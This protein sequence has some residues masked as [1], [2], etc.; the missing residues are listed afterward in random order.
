MAGDI[1]A[2]LKMAAERRRKAME[3]EGNATPQPAQPPQAHSPSPSPSGYRSQPPTARPAPPPPRQQ[4]SY[5]QRPQQPIQRQPA[6][7]PAP[8]VRNLQTNVYQ[9][10][11]DVELVEAQPIDDF[12]DVES[13]SPLAHDLVS[14]EVSS[15]DIA[16]HAEHLDD[17]WG[18]SLTDDKKAKAK[19]NIAADLLKMLSTPDS[20]TKAIVINEILKRPDFD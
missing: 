5:N 7:R 4:P 12:Y 2:F 13:K 3:A 8:P 14:S 9:T 20:I 19:K 6:R 1:E 10:N 15:E 18:N 17:H 16:S 11:D